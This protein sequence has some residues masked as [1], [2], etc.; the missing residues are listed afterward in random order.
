MYALMLSFI[1]HMR[2]SVLN[3]HFGSCDE[4]V[5]VFLWTVWATVTVGTALDIYIY[6]SKSFLGG[7]IFKGREVRENARSF[8]LEKVGGR[9]GSDA[10]LEG[11]WSSL[12]CN[13]WQGYEPAINWSTV[14][15]APR[16]PKLEEVNSPLPP[17]P[18]I[19]AWQ[20]LENERLYFA[21]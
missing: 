17:S 2:L 10:S 4:Q 11:P 8:Q 1:R 3:G 20:V 12:L 16:S 14:N 13:M 6:I 21:L 15:A 18:S 19:V 9:S 7:G 5:K